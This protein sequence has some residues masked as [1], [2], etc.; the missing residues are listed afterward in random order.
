MATSLGRGMRATMVWCISALKSILVF[1]SVFLRSSAAQ[2]VHLC[3]SQ[4]K[5]LLVGNAIQTFRRYWT[6]YGGWSALLRSP[7]LYIAFVITLLCR[8]LWA[9]VEGKGD[10]ADVCLS[11]LPNLLGFSMGGMAIMLAFSNATIFAAI[12]Q[13]GRDDSLF[14][15]V[16]ANFY[17]FILVQGLS[18]V[19]A[20][21]SKANPG[22]YLSF[23]G[24][25][26]MVYAI[27]VAVATAGQLLRTAEVFN[28]AGGIDDTRP[29]P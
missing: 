10:W 9:P 3:S 4:G 17:H 20:V 6:L 18:I 26:A 23:V 28:K 2:L 12:T 5:R 29:G 8:E 24:F 11:I 25:W 22:P 15:K 19:L 1:F 14:L 16:I 27:L 21:I 7:Y 13:K